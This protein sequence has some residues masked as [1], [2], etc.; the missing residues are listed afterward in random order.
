FSDPEG[1]AL[2]LCN[3]GDVAL[4]QRRLAEAQDLFAR[5][6]SLYNTIDDKGGL[7]AA[8][9]GLAQAAVAQGDYETGQTMLHQALTIAAA[10]G[11]T[12]LLIRVL[13]ATGAF[14]L[15]KGWVAQGLALLAL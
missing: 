10:I 14:L 9:N 7:A 15:Q 4:R 6:V 5:S 12:P 11:F 2:A 13:A 1:M 8:Y 3:L